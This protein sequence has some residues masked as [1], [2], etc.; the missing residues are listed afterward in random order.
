MLPAEE[1]VAGR[2]HQPLA[3]DDPLAAVVVLALADELLQHRRLGFLDLEEERVLIV[4]PRN[5][6]IQARVPTLPTPTTLRA[7]SANRNSSSR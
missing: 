5:S 6:T 1:D 7:M 2:L 3:G 4:R